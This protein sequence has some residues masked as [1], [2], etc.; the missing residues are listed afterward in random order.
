MNPGENARPAIDADS[1]HA[2]PPDEVVQRLATSAD[3]GLDAATAANRLE[4]YGP[5]RL[6]EGKKRGPFPPLPQPVQQY[7]CLRSSRARASP[8]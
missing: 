4:E 7:P 1:W 2:M 6:P 5:N 8:S 3:S